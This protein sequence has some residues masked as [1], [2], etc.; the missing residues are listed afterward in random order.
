MPAIPEKTTSK[1]LWKLEKMDSQKSI[2]KSL[3]ELVEGSQWTVL[4]WEDFVI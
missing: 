1:F 2:N 4:N 3:K